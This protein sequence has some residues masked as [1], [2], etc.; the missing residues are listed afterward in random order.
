MAGGNA[1]ATAVIEVKTSERRRPVAVA[2][3]ADGRRRSRHDGRIPRETK[4]SPGEE[5][6]TRRRESVMYD[7][8]PTKVRQGRDRSLPVGGHKLAGGRSKTRP[9]T[10][11]M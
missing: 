7:G 10:F 9:E 4:L 5:T 8:C 11:V 6:D 3:T 2:E 1:R